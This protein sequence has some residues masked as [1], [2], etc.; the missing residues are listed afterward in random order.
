M[1]E[2]DPCRRD[3]LVSRRLDCDHRQLSSLDDEARTFAVDVLACPTCQGRM[4]LL[5]LVKDPASIARCLATAGEVTE[6][7]RRPP[8]RGPPYWKSRVLRRQVLG[9]EHERGGRGRGANE[10]A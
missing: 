7:P 3:R 4:K 2:K 1:S 8:G 9:E 10:V 5:A 6:V